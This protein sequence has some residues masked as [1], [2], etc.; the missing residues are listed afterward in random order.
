MS[1]R[2]T[3]APHR[4]IRAHIADAIRSA[5]LAGE[6]QSGQRL[7]ERELAEQMG[8]SRAPIREALLQLEQEGFVETT[9]YRQTRVA[10]VNEV[11]VRELLLPIRTALEA[12]ALRR[13]MMMRDE[14]VWQSLLETVA[15]MQLAATQEDRAGVVEED[16][17]Y[18][19]VLMQAA[20]Y[21]HAIRLWASITPIILRTFYI[22][23]TKRSLVET[24]TGHETLLA[25]IRSGNVAKA[26]QVLS[27]HIAEMADV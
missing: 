12:F 16:L 6:L 4:S 8:T 19:R 5:I 14:K 22:G 24:V 11:E 26:E 2:L 25:A 1:L 23:T 9:P 20:G 27:D 10:G 18:H 21:P 15:E 17:E 7:V 13:F 3:V